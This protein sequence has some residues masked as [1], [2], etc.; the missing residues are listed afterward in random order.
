MTNLKDLKWKGLEYIKYPKDGTEK[1]NISMSEALEVVYGSYGDTDMS[2]DMLSIPN[3]IPC[4]FSEIE[5]VGVTDGGHK[6]VPM[7]GLEFLVPDG[8]EY[9]EKGNRL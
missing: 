8:A 7:A 1:R 5:V 4:R 9:D 2:R 6:L 3:R